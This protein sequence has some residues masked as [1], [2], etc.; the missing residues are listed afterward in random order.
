MHEVSLAVSTVM[1]SGCRFTLAGTRACFNEAFRA[2][3]HLGYPLEDVCM[4]SR[5]LALVFSRGRICRFFYV[6]LPDTMDICRACGAMG[7]DVHL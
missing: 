3:G 5:K 6:L 2:E 7:E 4:E 1:S